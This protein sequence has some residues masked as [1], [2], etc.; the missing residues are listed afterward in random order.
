[1]AEETVEGRQDE[2]AVPAGSGRHARFGGLWR[3][4]DFLK[5]WTGQTIS[6]LGS[7]ITRDGLPLLAVITL[8]ATPMQMGLLSAFGSVPVLLVGLAAGVWVDRMRRRPVLIL[9]DL[10]RA[11]LL[12]L[13]PLAAALGFLHIKQ[14][15]VIAALV[16]VLTVFF[17]V[18]YQAYLPSLVGRS[19]ILEGNSKLAVSSSFAELAGPGL[20]GALI[21][22]LT[23]PVA[24]LFDALSFLVSVLSI[25]VIRTPEPLPTPATERTAAVNELVE[26]VRFVLADPRLRALA[27]EAATRSFFGSFFG[28]L[29][30][31]YA[32]R[33]LGLGPAILGLTIAMGGVSDLIGSSLTPWIGRRFRLNQIL[34]GT[35]A[36]GAFAGFLVPLAR[37]PVLF[38]AL[39]LM[40]AQLFGDGLRTIYEINSRSFRQAVA[41]DR[42]LGRTSAS[43]Q[44]VAAGIGPLGALLAG[45]LAESIGV[46]ATL[47]VAAAG[48]GLSV[49]WLVFSPL[50]TARAHAHDPF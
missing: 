13:I 46:R 34:I 29:Y 11:L 48:G 22:A 14:L 26:G 40:G 1:M 15:Y 8:G 30:G 9:A 32:I 44:F 28:V 12:G 33:Y 38:G 50:R 45:L 37:P 10:G 5:L 43:M 36:L 42:L 2:I 23:A 16:G 20:A 41:P 18:A 4:P 47:F 7:R 49:L 27:G 24:I 17:D 31:L 39:M 6:E 19:Q 35:L 21:Q 25:A 3:H